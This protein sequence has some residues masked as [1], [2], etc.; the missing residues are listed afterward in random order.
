VALE[1]TIDACMCFY[2]E[3]DPDANQD[4]EIGAEVCFCG[5]TLDEHEQEVMV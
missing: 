4:P 2:Y 3:P 5:H 1:C